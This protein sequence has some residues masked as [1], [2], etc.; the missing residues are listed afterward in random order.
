MDLYIAGGC[1]EHG[2]NC[3]HVKA[4]SLC[5]LVD[6]GI[7]PGS[8]SDRYPHL[9]AEQIRSLDVVFLTHS[10]SDHSGA[11]MWL[12]HNGFHGT[13]IASME[14]LSQ[15]SLSQDDVRVLEEVC[16]Q[17]EG[18][19]GELEI[20]WGRSG[21]CA[22]SVWYKFIYHG[23]SILFSGD[24]T[25]R[26]A[27]YK[28][29][30]IRNET[31]DLAVL[32]C[33]YGRDNVSYQAYCRKLL[34][35]TVKK[36]SENHSVIFPVPKYGRGAELLT[37]FENHLNNITYYGDDHFIRNLEALKAEPF[38]RKKEISD[39]EVHLWKKGASGIIFLSDPQLISRS[40]CKIVNDALAHG[41][42]CI[43]TGNV[44]KGSESEHLLKEGLVN[45]IRYPV[46]Q[47]YHQYQ[48]LMEVNHFRQVIPYHSVNIIESHSGLYKI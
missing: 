17:G 35:L 18:I 21:H 26:T 6:C 37:L 42:S 1:G 14:T 27:F 34:L 15:L 2:R 12:H 47:N 25:E 45:L 11:L 24:Y 33:A 10:H 23:K 19:L 20:K 46:H 9:T 41:D 16:P 44:D 36:I 7:M 29:D 4:D 40:A 38:W 32:D 22:G 30:C 28:C 13:V 43:L 39:T 31:A 3:F 8:S 5:F 48:A